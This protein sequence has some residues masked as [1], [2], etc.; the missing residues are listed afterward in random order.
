VRVQAELKKA[1]TTAMQINMKSLRSKLNWGIGRFRKLQSTYMPAAIQALAKRTTPAEELAENVPLM[2]PSSLTAEER[3]GGGCTNGVLEI[4][5][6][7]RAA[8]CRTALPRLRNQ[9]HIKSRLLFYKKHNSRHQHM[10][11]RSRT[12]VARNESKIRLH[13][14]KFQMAW[15]ARVRIAN[16]DKSKIPWLPLRKEDIR[17]MQDA[18]E[19]SR[20]AEKRRKATERQLRR[21]EEMREDGLL[22]VVEDDGDDDMVTWGGEN[23]REISWIWTVAGSAGT[24]EELEDGEYFFRSSFKRWLSNEFFCIYSTAYRVVEGVGM[25]PAVDGGS[26]PPGRR[27]EAAAF[28]LRAP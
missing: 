18:E 17:C 6:S 11:T 9:L 7:L 13:S 5:D 28:V 21:E 8:Q 10:N 1:S 20:K 25:E 15:Q 23:M 3:E 24:D 14:E 26:S 16:G 27:V 4:E 22:P 2:L 12:I 19:L